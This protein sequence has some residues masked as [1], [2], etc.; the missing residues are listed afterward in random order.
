[1]TKK[2]YDTIRKSILD[3]LDKNEMSYSNI[4]QA[5]KNGLV[6]SFQGS[7][8]WYVEVVKLDL[9]ARKLI[10]RIPNTKPQLYKLIRWKRGESLYNLSNNTE[11]KSL[12]L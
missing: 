9:E 12:L 8:E 4:A 5:A 3:S 6:N 11:I 1:M 7:I 10:E 2:K